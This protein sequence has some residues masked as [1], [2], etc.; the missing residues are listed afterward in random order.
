VL[1]ARS[2]HFRALF[3]SEM[4]DSNDFEIRVPDD[5]PAKLVNLCVNYLYTNEIT[6]VSQQQLTPSD[7]AM[8]LAIATYY[9]LPLHLIE[10]CEL[11]LMKDLSTENATDIFLTAC[12]S[13]CEGLKSEATKFIVQNFDAVRA[14]EGW[15]ALDSPLVSDVL[16]HACELNSKLLAF[17]NPPFSVAPAEDDSEFCDG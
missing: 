7:T 10:L 6:E 8:I 17:A 1:S 2:G 15:H 9:D 11:S 3:E 5:F 4:R 16:A 12:E 14:T 13:A